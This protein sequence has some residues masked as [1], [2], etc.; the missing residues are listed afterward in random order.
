MI[1]EQ[2]IDWRA[3]GIEISKVKGGKG[4]CP[5]CHHSRKHKH[6]RSLS[7][8]LETGLYNC[9]NCEFQGSA[10]INVQPDRQRKVY[11]RPTPK[12]NK[13]S[14][15]AAKW[16]LTRGISENTLHKALVTEGLQWMPQV[17]KERNCICFNYYRN[18]ELINIKYRDA[19]KNFRM[20]KDAELI[21]YNLD[22]LKTNSS[23]CI[24]VEGEMD[25]LTII[26]AGIPI[27]VLSVPNGASK[28]SQRL[29]YLDNCWQ[30]F[31][32]CK[33]IILATD[34][35]E[36]GLAL[37]EELSR[38]LGKD[39]CM[40]VTFPE[41]CK[42][43]NEVFLSKGA[44]GVRDLLRSA[45]WIPLEGIERPEDHYEQS[46]LVMQNGYP[47]GVKAGLGEFDDLLSFDPA[48][49]TVITG[50]PGHG[51]ST[52]LNNV[53][54]GLSRRNNWIG[55]IFSPEMKP[56][57]FLTNIL[58]EIF[59]G[60]SIRKGMTKN[61][62]DVGFNFVNTHYQFLKIEEMDVSIDG[63][64]AKATELVKREGINFLVIDP[65]NYVE[66]KRPHGMT[67]TEYISEAL[68]KIKR[69][70]DVYSCHVFIVAHPAKIYPEQGKSTYRLP[71]MYDIAGS[72]H[73]YNKTDNGIV[74][75]K[76]LD[77]G[78]SE[79]HVQKVR[80]F[81]LGKEGLCNMIFNK[82]SKQ[83]TP[84]HKEDEPRNVDNPRAGIAVNGYQP[85]RPPFDAG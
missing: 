74:V 2:Q 62:F 16:F 18:G 49:L 77:A 34:N 70:K 11:R 84:E 36:A 64:L 26:E 47:E 19:E 22:A 12:E 83:F 50:I 79:I 76:N 55:A 58:I 48:G 4:F 27:P 5:S 21:F 24:I 35:D 28:G 81:F 54:I 38:R 63:I 65:W 57:H 41:G 60:K 71:K 15:A 39:R 37:R 8:N 13:P 1:G 25:A 10:M 61:E 42:D 75:Y 45:R 46:L 66:H 33:E 85:E 6:D 29:E 73:W 9:H 72:A 67:E 59:I 44:Q 23:V 68:S 69:F 3:K 7:V 17:E 80:W 32:E 78:V 56:Y 14:S 31:E 52:F 51:K 43:A 20:E 53:L 82:E 30:E 40:T